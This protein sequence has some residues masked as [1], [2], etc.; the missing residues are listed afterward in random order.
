MEAGLAKDRHVLM[1]LLVNCSVHDEAFNPDLAALR[2][3]SDQPAEPDRMFPDPITC[4]QS[5]SNRS[6]N[7]STAVA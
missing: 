6:R 5:R 1:L 3:A 2:P 4:G 7:C